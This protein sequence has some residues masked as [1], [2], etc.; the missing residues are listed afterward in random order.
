MPIVFKCAHREHDII[1]PKPRKLLLGRIKRMRRRVS[2]Q[3]HRAKKA[4]HKASRRRVS[5]LAFSPVPP[6][7]EPGHFRDTVQRFPG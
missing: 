4:G 5:R 6:T 3:K 1:A 7:P 2:L